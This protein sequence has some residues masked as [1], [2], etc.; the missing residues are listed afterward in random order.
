MLHSTDPKKLKQKE[1]TSKDIL[2]SHRMWNKIVI[3]GRWREVTGWE[4]G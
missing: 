2:I 1:V 4:R 3:R